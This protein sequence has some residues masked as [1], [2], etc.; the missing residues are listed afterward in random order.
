MDILS[1]IVVLA[2]ALGVGIILTLPFFRHS[3]TSRQISK[4][5]TKFSTEEEIQQLEADIEAGK[6]P[7]SGLYLVKRSKISGGKN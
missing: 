2:L 1:S 7:K 5:A 6:I 3:N 4:P